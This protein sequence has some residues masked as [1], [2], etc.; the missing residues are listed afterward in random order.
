MQRLH[1]AFFCL[2]LAAGA[3][4][5]ASSQGVGAFNTNDHASIASSLDDDDAYMEE[6]YVTQLIPDPL[7]GWNRA[8]FILNDGLT[9]YLA[10]PI[11]AGYT[12]IT[13]QPV[14][15]GFSNFFNNLYFPVRFINC[16]LQGKGQAAGQEFGK[17]IINSTAGLGGFV[18]YTALNHPE[19]KA[20]EEDFGQT[21]GV[22]G[23]GEGIYLYW[24]LL[25]PS[26]ARD[27]VGKVGDWAADPL[28]WVSP[29]WVAWTAKSMRTV[30]ELDGI[31]HLYDELTK[32]AIE[33]Y[34]AVRDAYTQYRRARIAK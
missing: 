29:A 11:N 17:F 4:G 16:L 3:S 5:C 10:R 7:E 32:S 8:M 6:A 28:T 34:T 2:L 25:G 9:N 14:R 23:V 33:P 20:G 1:F 13:P 24:P 22:W 30:N 12:A 19:L 26:N 15:S 18:N 31:L 27:S 21:L